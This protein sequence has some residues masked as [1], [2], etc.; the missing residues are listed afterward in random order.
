M[1]STHTRKDFGVLQHLVSFQ[2]WQTHENMPI[3]YMCSS[4]HWAQIQWLENHKE[5]YLERN[6]MQCFINPVDLTGK[7]KPDPLLIICAQLRN[8]ITL[9][10]HL[11]VWV[12]EGVYECVS[13]SLSCSNSVCLSIMS[14]WASHYL[15]T[16]VL[17]IWYSGNSGW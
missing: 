10:R 15:L 5:S 8:N 4:H 12:W 16:P 1:Q 6:E 9:N 17:Y 11:I 7:F 2:E 3:N 13:V 14:Q